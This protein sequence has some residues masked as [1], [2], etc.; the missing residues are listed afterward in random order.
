[1]KIIENGE[2][3]YSE[4]ELPVLDHSDDMNILEVS[5]NQQQH[6]STDNEDSFNNNEDNAESQSSHTDEQKDKVIDYFDEVEDYQIISK[7]SSNDSS[8]DTS[9]NSFECVDFNN[10]PTSTDLKLDTKVITGSNSKKFSIC[11]VESENT[12]SN[13][14]DNVE[15]MYNNDRGNFN[16][17]EEENLINA[18]LMLLKQQDNHILGDSVNKI[19][20]AEIE[21][22]VSNIVDLVVSK[23][24]DEDITQDYIDNSKELPLQIPSPPSSPSSSNSSSSLSPKADYEKEKQDELLSLPDDTTITKPFFTSKLTNSQLSEELSNEIGLK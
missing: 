13:H 23:C 10:S 21:A 22:V 6:L 11:A 20:D 4:N 5:D 8:L 1:M 16:L 9:N 12:S 15:L 24:K 19:Y 14:T 17:N 3:T 18:Q 7:S 2:L